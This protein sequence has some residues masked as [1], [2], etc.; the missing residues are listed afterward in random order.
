M[1]H[2]KI[3][4]SDLQTEDV[5]LSIVSKLAN[6]VREG[7]DA[8]S[9]IVGSIRATNAYVDD[10]EVLEEELPE[11][12][13]NITGGKYIRFADPAVLA[14]LN[15]NRYASTY[16]SDGTGITDTAALLITTLSPNQYTHPFQGNTEI[17]SFNE[18]A[19]FTN[20]SA[21]D[22][23][24]FYNCTNLE[25]VD[26][27][28]IEEIGRSAFQGCSSL[29][30]VGDTSKLKIIGAYGFNNC[31]ITSLD[32]S[33]VEELGEGA[34]F[35][36]PI[37]HIDLSSL[38]TLGKQ[39]LAGYEG[40]LSLPSLETIGANTFANCKKITYIDDLGVITELPGDSEFSWMDLCVGITL[41]STLATIADGALM[42][43]SGNTRF[44]KV[45]AT[46]P[47]TLSTTNNDLSN[48]S[49]LKV[50]VP[51]A[52]LNAYKAA[53]GWSMFASKIYDMDQFAIDFPNET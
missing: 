52:S 51:N 34:L 15:D 44:I 53:S 47:P 40:R 42:N 38:K 23:T 13:I 37:G 21:I 48:K 12:E 50:Y 22:V 27:K 8:S 11:L 39:N 25:S 46:T 19:K 41:P 4:Q 28:N 10:V 3:I 32:L 17:V 6:W 30:S 45:L 2:L 14:V 26:L 33:N 7:L 16:H 43:I 1:K 35:N 9:R 20:L 36:V 31:P 5:N 24:S 49:N 29:T 18:L